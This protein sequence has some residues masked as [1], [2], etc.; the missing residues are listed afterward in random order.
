MTGP[1]STPIVYADVTR[2][3]VL[4]ESF[5]RL[6]EHRPVEVFADPVIRRGLREL[7]GLSERRF[8]EASGR[9]ALTRNDGAVQTESWG[10]R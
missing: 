2:V 5:T 10:R 3:E 8:I 6:L 9:A 7:S 1:G 4:V